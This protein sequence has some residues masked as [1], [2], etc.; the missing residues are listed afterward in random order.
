MNSKISY[1]NTRSLGLAVAFVLGLYLGILV[2]ALVKDFAA[3]CYRFVSFRA[4]TDLATLQVS[5]VNHLRHT[6][7]SIVAVITFIIV[8]FIV[9]LSG[10]SR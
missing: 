4:W 5:V 9:F 10:E 7:T 1:R 2:Q 8:A 6:V 3:A